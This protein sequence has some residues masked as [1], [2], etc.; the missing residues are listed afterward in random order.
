MSYLRLI[1]KANNK[2]QIILNRYEIYGS[3]IKNTGFSLSAEAY[4]TTKTIMRFTHVN[5]YA[6]V[7]ALLHDW[8]H[9][10]YGPPCVDNTLLRDDY[11]TASPDHKHEIKGAK[12]LKA[13]G[14]PEEVYMPIK[15][16]V[17]AKR[18]LC[19]IDDNYYENLPYNAKIS[20]CLQGGAMTKKE[21]RVFEKVK[22]FHPSIILRTA[23]DARHESNVRVGH[24]KEYSEL[25][26]DVLIEKS[27]N[28]GWF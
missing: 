10:C 26:K 7:A 12:N 15:Y 8:G 27:K 3:E 14:F 2:A 6:M 9:I 11:L 5:K 16:H 19:F 22:W 1:S 13:M 18:Y 17:Q 24:I 21:A 25:I 28:H 20:L 23:D 4:L